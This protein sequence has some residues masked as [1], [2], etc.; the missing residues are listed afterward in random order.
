[1]GKG[2]SS[3]ANEF[4]KATLQDYQELVITKAILETKIPAGDKDQSPYFKAAHCVAGAIGCIKLSNDGE[5]AQ[6]DMDLDMYAMRLRMVERL[7]PEEGLHVTP[8][9]EKIREGLKQTMEKFTPAMA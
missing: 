8:Y 3:T 6:L 4:R 1:M 9:L 7:I 2:R 5:L